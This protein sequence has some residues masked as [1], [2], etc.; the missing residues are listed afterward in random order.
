[1]QKEVR[2]IIILGAGPSGLF[3]GLHL[4]KQA[5]VLFL[6]KSE[7]PASKLLL[8]AKGRGNLTNLQINPK[9]DYTCDNPNFVQTAFEKYG[10]K[11]FLQFLAES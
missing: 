9:Q 1:M 11:E 6:E 8:S 3:C 2:D 7:K 4:P 10:A 5:K